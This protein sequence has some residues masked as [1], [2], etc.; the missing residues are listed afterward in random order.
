MFRKQSIIL[1]IILLLI[2]P[3]YAADPK[4]KIQNFSVDEGMAQRT[5]SHLLQDKRGFMWFATWSGLSRYDGYS[6]VNYKKS[7]NNSYVPE[8]NRINIVKENSEGNIWCWT[9]DKRAYLFDVGTKNYINILEPIEQKTDQK[10]KIKEI[11]PLSKGVSWI[12]CEQDICFRVVDNT[13]SIITYSALNKDIKGNIIHS[14]FEDADG[15]E[16][17]LTNGGITVMGNKNIDS[18]IPFSIYSKQGDR[19][20]LSTQN[21]IMAVYKDKKL[22]HLSP[23]LKIR[24]VNNVVALKNSLYAIMT[25]AGFLIYD[26]NSDTFKSY[27]IECPFDLS[28]YQK[29]DNILWL[30]TQDLSVKEINLE[31]G[32]V[33]KRANPISLSMS[34]N[35]RRRLTV[36]KD[37][38]NTLWVITPDGFL[39]YYDSQGE[40]F[41]KVLDYSEGSKFEEN[42]FKGGLFVDNQNNLWLQNLNGIS[43]VTFFK[44]DVEYTELDKNY[45]TRALNIDKHNNVWIGTKAGFIR[46]FDE[47][48]RLLGYLSPNGQLTQQKVNFVET[49]IYSIVEDK[50]GNVWIG[51]KGEGLFQLK[52]KSDAKYSFLTNNYKHNISDPYSIS[53]NDVYFIFPDSNSRIWVGTFGKGLNL[54]RH[55]SNNKV[56]FLSHNNLLK[57]YPVTNFGSIRSINESKDE[58]I[59]VGTTG[60]LLTFSSDFKN[61]DNIHFYENSGDLNRHNSITGNNVMHIIVSDNN[62]DIFIVTA[63]GGLNKVV[64]SNLLS[65]NIA[66]QLLDVGEHKTIPGLLLSAIEDSES[67]IWIIS[68]DAITR[69]TP[70]NNRFDL[71]N[72]SSLIHNSYY[73]EA[74]PIIDS[75]GHLIV[76]AENG[77]ID[78]N[79][80]LMTR[81]EYIPPI[82]FT[83]INIQNAIVNDINKISEIEL[84]PSR[85]NV[86]IHFSTLDYINTQDINYAYRLLG[87]E[88]DWNYVGKNRSVSY[89]NLP[90]GEYTFQVRSTNSNGTW[91]DNTKELKIIVKPKFTE[92]IWAW[93]LGAL[94]ILVIGFITI[95]IIFYI[96]RLRY[97]VDFEK[98]L[99]DIKLRFFTD[100]SHEL[101]TPLTLIT[102]PMSEVL[103]RNDLS[104]KTR[105]YLNIVNSNISRM[106]RMINQILDF[107]KIQNK[108]MKLLIENIDLISLTKKVMGNFDLIKEEKQIN[109]E[110]KHS[111]DCLFCWVD[112]DKF[113][114]ILFNL[115][116][117]AF[118]FT[119]SGSSITV[120]IDDNNESVLVSVT[121]TGI[122]MNSSKLNNLFERFESYSTYNSMQTSSGIGLSMVKELANMHHARIEVK[123]KINEGSEFKI[124]FLKGKEHFV[125]DHFVEFLLN[126]SLSETK[127]ESNQTESNL[128]INI[129]EDLFTILIVE[130]NK[131]LAHFLSSILA[132]SYKIIE[133]ANGKEGLEKAIKT[134]PDFILTDI[135]MPVMDGLD[136]IKEIKEN[137]DICHIPIIALSSKASLDDRIKGLEYGIDDYITK[138]FSAT[139]LKT[140]IKNLIIQR[141]QLQ[142]HFIS[143]IFNTDTNAVALPSGMQII[144]SD[145]IFIQDLMQY[146]DT[147]IDNTELTI[148][149]LAEEMQL[150][151]SIFY[152]K[153]KS[154]LGLSPIDF[155]LKTR[156]KRAAQLINT[157]EFTFSQIAYMTGFSDP[158]Y[159]GKCFKKEMGVS[160]SEFK[161]NLK[162]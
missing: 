65:N 31:T 23:P 61:V 59:L 154:I 35:P 76:G 147:N 25:N 120:K 68:E 21:G 67:N 161:K 102:G 136:M 88:S 9:N 45:E 150:S 111:K 143:D 105:E 101:R 108:K 81:N 122:G 43:K 129:S 64:D 27:D 10:Y 2:L 99:T 15:N 159:F 54:I 57:N 55:N 116:S 87:L 127:N 44:N 60:G 134:I 93:I 74:I 52:S 128:D 30:I 151:R 157:N 19:I 69:Y 113:E 1:P 149:D 62:H 34:T 139:Y 79:R 18:K 153:I 58:V 29:S 123:S 46:I 133:A 130:D 82:A 97:K 89:I 66:F 42:W 148:D 32:S 14:V 104:P 56:E 7:A 137:K 72:R 146:M 63:D 160:P 17:I 109:F 92:T 152:R 91:V 103:E 4:F 94:L 100:I 114:K 3:V 119:P 6:F 47:H 50:L 40:R 20:F 22:K 141:K 71:F 121:D 53:G 131:E 156:I 126:D 142:D 106:G 26:C 28:L 144:K 37:I 83:E 75:K 145:K 12:V 135:V 90:E 5:V 8:N 13:R 77:V 86:S 38:N 49:G 98:Q 39:A 84:V 78:V 70:K 138:P 11:F 51:T 41:K 115:L 125:N 155:I 80:S 107:R 73:S 24:N 16:W 95:Y 33:N 36:Y 158:K 117:N 140:R 162:S 124:A 85:R 118:K 132:D 48:K 96:Y 110:L 112:A